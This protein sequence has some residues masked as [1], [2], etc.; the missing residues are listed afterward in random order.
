MGDEHPGTGEVRFSRRE[1]DTGMGD[2]HTETGEGRLCMGDVEL[3]GGRSVPSGGAGDR[4]GS[5]GERR[6]DYKIL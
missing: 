1:V 3:L 6:W 2:E 5:P 4:P